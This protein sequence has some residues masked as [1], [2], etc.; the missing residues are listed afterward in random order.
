M[1]TS[2]TSETTAHR[3]VSSYIMLSH[4]ELK[5]RCAELESAMRDYLIEAHVHSIDGL[6]ECDHEAGV[7][8]C[9]YH[10]A[11]ARALDVLEDATLTRLIRVP[12][13]N[14]PRLCTPCQT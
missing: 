4:D 1:R 5:S 2:G 11:L 12:R 14:G 7:C 3:G 6:D 8:F 13:S 10:V 9:A